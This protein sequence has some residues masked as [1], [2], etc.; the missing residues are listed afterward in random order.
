[1]YGCQT[2]ARV[3]I[4][5]RIDEVYDMTTVDQCQVKANLYV[6]GIRA[7]HLGV[8]LDDHITSNQVGELSVRERLWV[9]AY[10]RAGWKKAMTVWGMNKQGVTK[11]WALTAGA[12][13]NRACIIGTENKAIEV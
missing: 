3:R 7:Y 13:F 8:K 11:R 5:D 1:L 6:Q 10:M 12:A 4:G 2:G 9:K